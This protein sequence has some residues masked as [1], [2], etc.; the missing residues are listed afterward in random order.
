M[1]EYAIEKRSTEPKNFFAG[2]F[3]TVTETG[4]AGAALA[5]YTP[6]TTNEDGKVVAVA[7]FIV[8]GKLLHKLTEKTDV[9]EL[10]TEFL[11]IAGSKNLYSGRYYFKVGSF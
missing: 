1:G 8:N 3:P 9:S 11:I 6:I 2:E 4:T 7:S 10:K 5:A